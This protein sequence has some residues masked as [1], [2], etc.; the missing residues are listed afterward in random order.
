MSDPDM[1]TAILQLL[2]AVREVKELVVDTRR[3]RTGLEDVSLT[4]REAAE[5]LKVDDKWLLIQ[6]NAG[7]ISYYDMG[8]GRKFRLVDLISFRENFRTQHDFIVPLRI[9]R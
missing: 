8:K 7:A 1:K 9:A 6:A 3:Q 5:F 2:T 4:T